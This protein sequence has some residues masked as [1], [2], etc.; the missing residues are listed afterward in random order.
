M[1]MADSWNNFFINFLFIGK[2]TLIN[3]SVIAA[4]YQQI[5]FTTATFF[6]GSQQ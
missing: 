5:D 6:I 1:L 3:W 4:L 2:I